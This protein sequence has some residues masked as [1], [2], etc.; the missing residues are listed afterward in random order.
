MATAN[1]SIIQLAHQH[2]TSEN[3]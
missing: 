3:A 2:F 1:T